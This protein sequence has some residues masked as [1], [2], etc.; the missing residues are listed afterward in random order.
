MGLTFPKF[1]IARLLGAMT[2]VALGFGVLLVG[3]GSA[4]EFAVQITISGAFFGGAIGLIVGRPILLALIGAG[5]FLSFALR[6][7]L[8]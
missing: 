3:P 5:L 1:T 6:A 8:T 2:L 4:A 7:T